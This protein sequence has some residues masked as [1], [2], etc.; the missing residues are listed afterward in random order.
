M[1]LTVIVFYSPEMHSAVCCVDL[2]IIR[3]IVLAVN[4]GAENT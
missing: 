1:Q 3:I 4:G 2:F